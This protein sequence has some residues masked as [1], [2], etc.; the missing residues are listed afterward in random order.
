MVAR[1]IDVPAAECIIQYNGPQSIENYIHRVGRTGR[2]GK[3]G[4]SIIFLTHEEQEFVLKMESH[5]VL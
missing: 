2:A 5:K 3:K 1:G 4:T